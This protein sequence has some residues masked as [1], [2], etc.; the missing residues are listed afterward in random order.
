MTLPRLRLSLYDPAADS[1]IVSPPDL[2]QG[3]TPLHLTLDVE[4]AKLLVDNG[5]NAL[6]VNKV[7]ASCHRL[8]P[9]AFFV[10][11]TPAVH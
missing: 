10:P 11:H 1:R 4:M 6:A 3:N 7:R 9:A 5:A 8:A 2:T